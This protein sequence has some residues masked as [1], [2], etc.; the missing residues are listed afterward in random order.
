MSKARILLQYAPAL[1]LAA[2]SIV[3]T[4][5]DGARDWLQYERT[6]VAAGQW[7]RLVSA[8]LVHAGSL[9]L[10]LNLAGLGIAW[11]LV[12]GQWR[13][14]TWAALLTGTALAV[15]LGLWWLVP[16]IQWYVGAS[17]LLHG[18]LAAG[19]VGLWRAW[20]TGAALL[21][22]MLALKALLDASGRMPVS[23]WAG[24]D[25]IV[26]AHWLGSLAGLALAGAA[27]ALTAWT[28]K[29]L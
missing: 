26:Q 5:A 29:R 2:C 9:H 18:L 24:I 19:A 28:G 1:V 25:V 3:A 16:G 27:L 23:G 8:H 13:P 6:A 17:G 7:W 21:L 15:G 11:A 4:Y 14:G 10:A 12:G 20:R 22:G